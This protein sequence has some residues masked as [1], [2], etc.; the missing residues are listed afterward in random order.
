MLGT[1]PRAI[2]EAATGEAERIVNHHGQVGGR[3]AYGTGG[4]ERSKWHTRR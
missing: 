1:P 4:I 2:H 3:S